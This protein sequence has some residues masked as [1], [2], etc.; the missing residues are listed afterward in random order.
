MIELADRERCRSFDHIYNYS[1]WQQTPRILKLNND[2]K[3]LIL[4]TDV[5][6]NRRAI[7]HLGSESLATYAN[8]SFSSHIVLVALDLFM[9]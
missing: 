2:Y 7:F 4:C 3:M 9:Y 5:R 8:D 6:M 1:Y